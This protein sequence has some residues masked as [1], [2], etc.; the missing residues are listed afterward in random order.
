[1]SAPSPQ[2]MLKLYRLHAHEFNEQ[3]VKLFRAMNAADK[4]ELLFHMILNTNMIMQQ[5]HKQ[6]EPGRHD[7]QSMP[8]A[9]KTN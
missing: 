8:D 2:D 9:P 1:M 3:Q 4:L 7:T 6:I 5:I